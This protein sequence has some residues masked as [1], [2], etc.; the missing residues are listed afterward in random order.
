MRVP[1]VGDRVTVPVTRVVG[2]AVGVTVNGVGVLVPFAVG[3]IGDAVDVGIGSVTTGVGDTTGVVGDGDGATVGAAAVVSVGGAGWITTAAD[4][5][6]D[7]AV[8]TN[9]V[10]SGV[11]EGGSVGDGGAAGNGDGSA[12]VAVGVLGVGASVGD[13]GGVTNRTSGDGRAVATTT[14]SC[15]AGEV[16]PKRT[17]RM[18]TPARKA[19][20]ARI[21]RTFGRCDGNQ[22]MRLIAANYVGQRLYR[23]SR[24][25][26]NHLRSARRLFTEQKRATLPNAIIVIAVT[27]P[28]DNMVPLDLHLR[29]DHP[30]LRA[31]ERSIVPEHRFCADQHNR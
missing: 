10:A 8:A 22:F 9:G 1:G 2:V 31:T 7:V 6:V 11:A 20:A 13:G 21:N 27:D 25:P 12:D 29:V 28:Q 30:R 3:T 23:A 18:I 5:A 16:P 14:A 19:S 15:G 26:V 17:T 4:V 24:S